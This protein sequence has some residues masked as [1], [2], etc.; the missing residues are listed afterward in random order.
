MRTSLLNLSVR[1]RADT[2][3]Q[4]TATLPANRALVIRDD[5]FYPLLIVDLIAGMH[6]ASTVLTD[7]FQVHLQR[8]LK[9]RENFLSNAALSITN[10][11]GN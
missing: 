5:S 3:V 4:I 2:D 10:A 11:A 9:H 7:Y 8:V 6:L 1:E